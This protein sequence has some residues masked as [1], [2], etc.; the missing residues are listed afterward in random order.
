VTALR[1]EMPAAIGLAWLLNVEVAL[2][3]AYA[4]LTTFTAHVDLAPTA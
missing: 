3:L 2:D 4:N 1:L